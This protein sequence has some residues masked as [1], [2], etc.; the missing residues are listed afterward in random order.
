MLALQALVIA[1]CTW[2]AA[3][4]CP[5]WLRW[6]V[7][8]GAPLVAGLVNGLLLGNLA[9]GL[10]VGSN[11]MMAYIGMVA[12][13][14]SLP[15]DYALAGYLGVAMTMLAGADPSVGLTI[16]VPLGLLGLLSFN[17]KMSL[18]SVWV[19]RADKYA[20]QGNARGVV[21][22]NLFASQ[23]FPF[24]TYAIPSF[25]CVLFGSS[26]LESLMQVIPAQVTSILSLAGHLIP[27]LGLAML[28]SVLFKAS[29]LPFFAIG[30]AL[31]AY[32]QL[33]TMPIAI[34][35]AAVGVLHLVYTSRE[36]AG[37][38]EGFSF[39]PEA[40]ADIAGEAAS[41]QRHLSKRAL[42]KSWLI[43]QSWGQI[44]YNYE[45]MMGL[46]FCHCMAPVLEELYG[47]D[48]EAI[49]AGLKRHLAYFN[50]ENTWGSIIPGITAAMEE[51]RANGADIDDD[52]ENNLKT[53]LMGPMAGIGDSVTQ[54]L[55]RVVLLSIAIGLAS[56]GSAL[57][58]VLLIVLFSAYALGV[59]YFCYNAGYR[60]GKNAVTK[61]LAGGLVKQLTEGLGAMGMMVLG[62]LVAT[63]IPIA[64]PITLQLAT[65]TIE[66]QSILD[67]ILPRLLPLISFLTTYHFIKRGVKP[68]TVIIAMFVIAI[69]LSPLG[70]LS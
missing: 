55:V 59:G 54:S 58:P 4:A 57:G 34:I 13:G 33:G 10:A 20:E 17:V 70:I 69:I 64:C 22:M 48:R 6:S 68:T 12:I 44:C 27:A 15:S 16:A 61:L 40:A 38:L 52:I 37:V 3:T 23:I 26:A 5:M 1:L 18:N 42:R 19:H 24:I 53:A 2:Y 43:W 25:L 50:T 65:G 51:Q 62:C 9:Y 46:G 30:F 41:G 11:V 67:T 45:R 35:G 56:Q 66:V 49:A 31:A 29:L 39:G 28:M 8:F 60:F 36:G 63:V 7:Y 14:G 21:A 32:L 47:D